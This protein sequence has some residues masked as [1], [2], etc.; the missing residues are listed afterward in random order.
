[1][2]INR[3]V[4]ENYG[5]Y[6]G[7]NELELAPRSKGELSRPIIL[8][9][10]MNGAGKT[11]LLDAVRLALYGKS[12]VGD[13]ISEKRY[14][15]HLR[16]L[17]HR[18]RSSLVQFDFARVGVDFD[19]VFRGT[20]ETYYVQRSWSLRTGG[21]VEES[22][23]V[24]KHDAASRNGDYSTWPSLPD[25]EPE[26]WQ[27]F[28]SDVV[29]E[30]LS[31]LFFFDGEKIK[32][33]ADDISGDRAIAGSIRSLLGLDIVVRLKADLTILAA[34]ETEDH[35]DRAEASALD[36]VLAE[37]EALDV[38]VA[39]EEQNRA[40]IE[41]EIRGAEGE[42]KRLERQ[43]QEQ[44]GAFAQ[45]R[46]LKQERRRAL[47]GEIQDLQRRIRLESEGLF[48]LGLCPG[49]A[50]A[51]EKQI[52]SESRVRRRAAVQ[53]EI[54]DLQGKIIRKL[55]RAV[56]LPDPRGRR[57]AVQIVRETVAAQLGHDERR[58]ARNGVQ[59]GLSK[60][61]EGQI[62]A[63]LHEAR[64]AAAATVRRLC[65]EIEAKEREAQEIERQLSR[66]PDQMVLAPVFADLSVQNQLLGQKRAELKALDERI[67]SARNE[68][69]AKERERERLMARGKE[70]ADVR[71]RLE[72]VGKVQG[73]LNRY[74][75]RLTE[76]K[77]GAL[78]RAVTE[79][80]NRLSRKGDLLHGISIDPQ[81]F[82]VR[83]HGA[84][85]YT[86]PRGELSAGEKQILAI[87]ILWGLART[88]GRPLPVIIDTPLG[89]LDS[90]HRMNLVQN[91]FPHAG[92]QVVLLSTDT[93]VD[94]HLFEEMK[95]HISHCYHLV[96]DKQE[97]RT[98]AR[99]EYFWK[100]H[101]HA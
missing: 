4:L 92:H 90:A 25:L 63:W 66:A 53:G 40:E 74:L 17:V 11:T 91:Y 77:V 34:R 29:P 76:I 31:Q 41:T 82:E 23:Q 80:F 27:A 13:R 70:K 93:E 21:S 64:S 7:R 78:C 43:L 18:S 33:I 48:P 68:M 52:D 6:S 46:P 5:L 99:Q 15:E 69:A 9:G 61:D 101:I 58:S 72:V 95:P 45:E 8:I 16:G 98:C 12:A 97:R 60:S 67:A 57:E 3:V 84:E 73:A 62:L 79:C 83:L 56:N 42:I 87:S 65:R 49:V 85:G 81:T 28:V 30:R 10:G 24:C 100:E 1:M 47:E 19:L 55:S 50:K 38:A 32:S 71:S 26:H 36:R 96:Y 75:A 89:R 94:R 20:R 35:L 86:I 59:L 14:Q 37:I 44:G 51:L 54:Q 88:S 22:L 39:T 2:R